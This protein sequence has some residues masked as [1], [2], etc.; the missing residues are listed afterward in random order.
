[1]WPLTSSSSGSKA[2]CHLIMMQN[3]EFFLAI[4]SQFAPK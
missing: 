4:K 2:L 3:S 1:V